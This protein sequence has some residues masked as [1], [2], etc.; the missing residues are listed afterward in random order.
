VISFG[1]F[2]PYV[3]I[4]EVHEVASRKKIGN[5]VVTMPPI[6]AKAA[7][8]LKKQFKNI[9]VEA[10]GGTSKLAVSDIV[11]SIA[12]VDPVPWFKINKK[13]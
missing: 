8:A 4:V 7:A 3:T 10:L 12:T 1:K 13:K 11:V 5:V 6:P 2:N 9:V